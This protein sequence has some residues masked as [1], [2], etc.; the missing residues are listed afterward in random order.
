[1]KYLALAAAYIYIYLKDGRSISKVDSK[2]ERI[3]FSVVYCL[4]FAYTALFLA[5][6][7]LPSLF[8]ALMR[9]MEKARILN[10]IAKD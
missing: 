9:L 4:S 2:R 3:A 7:S 6:V 10:I 8:E 5:G 1:M